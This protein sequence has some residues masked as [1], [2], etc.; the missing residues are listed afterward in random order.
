M[1]VKQ[2]MVSLKDKRISPK[3]E[4]IDVVE[5]G[6]IVSERTVNAK[7]FDLNNGKRQAKVYSCPIHWKDKDGK[8]KNIDLTV[9]RKPLADDLPQFEYETKSGVYHAHFTKNKPWNYRLV[10][11]DSWIEYEALFE[12]SDSLQIEVE[13]T[14]VGIKETIT[15]LDKNAPTILQWKIDGKSVDEAPIYLLKPHAVDAKG[16]DVPVTSDGTDNLILTYELDTTNAVFPVVLDP[17]SVTATNDGAPGGANAVYNTIRNSSDPPGLD[18][19]WGVGQQW[20]DPYYYIYRSFGSFALPEMSSVSACSLFLNGYGDYSD[21][22][23]DIYIHTSTHSDPLVKA[24]FDLFDGHQATGSYNGTVLNNSWNSVDYS[25]DWNEIVFNG[26]G[27]TAVLAKQN[28]TF[29]I[30]VISKEDYGNSTPTNQEKVTFNQSSIG[31]SEPYLSITYTQAITE[32]VSA[33]V[34]VEALI[35][36]SVIFPLSALVETE[37]AITAAKAAINAVSALLEME[38]TIPAKWE[39]ISAVSALVEMEATIPGTKQQITAV[40]VLLELE[41]DTIDI[42]T[43]V[44][45]LIPDYLNWQGTWVATTYYNNLDVVLHLSGD[46]IHAFVSKQDHNVGNNPV[47]VYQWWTRLI[48]E[49]WL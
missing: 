4:S 28:D 5:N 44:W 14:N 13:T 2:G 3:N 41:I 33:L 8:F 37:V 45:L 32:A 29:N 21:T 18:V 11:G 25:A 15:L 48:Q 40:S 27:L 38:A 47:T 7:I 1:N 9:K 23:F 22:D 20:V 30:V 43:D 19:R 24:D 6:E 10:V 34:E 42:W 35:P 36:S 46:E 17:T 49:Q 39:A 26:A 16:N 12:E 31:G